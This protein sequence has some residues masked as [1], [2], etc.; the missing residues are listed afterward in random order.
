MLMRI[1]TARIDALE[2]D[3]E[4]TAEAKPTKRRTT[5]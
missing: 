4:E 1:S 5:Q 3:P 2:A